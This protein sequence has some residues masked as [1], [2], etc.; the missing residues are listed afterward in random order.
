MRVRP[1]IL[2]MSVLG[3]A[4]GLMGPRATRAE[5]V[6][7][8]AQ[9]IVVTGVVPERRAIVVDNAGKIIEI[10][11]NTN[12]DIRPVVMYLRQDGAKVPLTPDIYARYEAVMRQVR[13]NHVAIIT[14]VEEPMG[15]VLAEYLPQ[16]RALA[17]DVTPVQ[18][19][20]NPEAMKY[21]VWVG[22]R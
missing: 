18:A 21:R 8:A 6:F 3:M 7:S 12:N 2:A 1:A 9:Q 19:M 20:A 16:G 17:Y 15:D 10:T 5:L 13:A 11:S 22:A 4:F 14:L